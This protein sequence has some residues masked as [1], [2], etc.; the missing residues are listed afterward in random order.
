MARTDSKILIAIMGSLRA[1]QRQREIAASANNF[2]IAYKIP[3]LHGLAY[4]SE[5]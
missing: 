2:R 4:H 1:R 5:Q 3:S